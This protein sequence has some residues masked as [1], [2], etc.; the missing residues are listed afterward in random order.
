MDSKS[1]NEN[2]IADLFT[3]LSREVTT[4]LRQE[5]GLAK[6]EMSEKA[7]QATSGLISLVVGGAV[8]YAGVLVLLMA[9]V[10]AL[11]LFLDLWL[12]ALI[13]A[14]VVLIIGISMIGKAK[15]NLK[16]RLMAAES[17]YGGRSHHYG[18][19]NTERAKG[20]LRDKYAEKKSQA[21]DM[22]S[23]ASD[24][25]H[26]MS[27]TMKERRSHLQ[28]K[29]HEWSDKMQSKGSD[30][31]GQPVILAAA[32]LVVGSLL[33]MS[34]PITAREQEMMGEKGEELFEK[35]EEFGREKFKEGQ[36]A[37]A[38]AGETFQE[39][40]GKKSEQESKPS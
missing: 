23:G 4:L 16:M 39:E 6:T 22:V 31:A 25:M 38:A 15:A 34:L 9:A 3:D 19:L 20:N 21:A 30:I 13:V 40:L 12:S 37:A 32:G 2:S 18:S 29:G 33:A 11:G 17:N 36:E 7:G 14:V 35:A 8:A 1:G 5:F 24:K 26:Q 27:A 10:L 28:S